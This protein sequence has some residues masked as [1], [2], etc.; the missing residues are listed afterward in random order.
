MLAATFS[1]RAFVLS[2]PLFTRKASEVPRLRG[3]MRLEGRAFFRKANRHGTA[4]SSNGERRLGKTRFP[5]RF[6]DSCQTE[7]A[8]NQKKKREASVDVNEERRNLVF[9]TSRLC[10]SRPLQLNEWPGFE[11]AEF[12]FIFSALPLSL[13]Y[14]GILSA[15]FSSYPTCSQFSKGAR[16]A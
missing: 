16:A 5:F 15:F 12:V 3:S 9:I 11:W 10:S 7:Q 1:L 8:S 14:F 13:A 2:W 6:R 4:A